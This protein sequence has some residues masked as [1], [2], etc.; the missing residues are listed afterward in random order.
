ML[1]E[2]IAVWAQG[3]SSDLQ[4]PQNEQTKPGFRSVPLPS[5][6][7][8]GEMRD[9]H[10]RISGDSTANQRAC[11]TGDPASNKMKGEAVL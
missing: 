2:V 5:L 3:Q 4:H 8:C 1:G 10:R 7:S 9:G 11:R 6:R